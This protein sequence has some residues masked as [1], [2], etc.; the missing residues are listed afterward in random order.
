MALRPTM[1]AALACLLSLAPV[2]HAATKAS[3][4]FDTF[5]APSGYTLNTVE[6]IADDGTVVG[7]LI[8]N[9]SQ[10]MVGFMLS[11]SGDFTIYSAPK[12]SMTWLYQQNATGTS[13]GSYADS[14]YKVHG[15]T[16]VNN[17]FAS[18][19]YPGA[20]NTW[21]FGVNHVGSLTGSYGSGGSINGFLFANGNYT[22]INYPKGA[23][24]YPMAINDN[25]A[26]VGS[27]L[28]GSVNSGFLWQNGNFT[29][30]SY[31]KSKYGTAL[32]GINNAGVIVGNRISADKAFAF[33]YQN[34][35]FKSIVYDGAKFEVVGGINNNGVISGQIYYTQSQTVGF[36]AVCK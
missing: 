13:S 28:N 29:T 35:T 33:L 20:A 5:D 7:Q 30:I 11:A 22:K 10:N 6:G 18:F 15:F 4:T 25:N 27:S 36:T 2:L 23:V 31:P 3:C 17:K 14:K 12:S 8:E 21:L 16:L 19:D 9:K 26:V 32:T 24:T 34:G 1:L